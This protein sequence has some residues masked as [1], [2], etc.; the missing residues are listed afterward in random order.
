MKYITKNEFK[1]IVQK[2]SKGN[3]RDFIILNTL[4]KSGVRAEELTNITHNDILEEEEQLIIRGKG[5]VIRNVDVPPDLIMLLQL[6]IK[7]NRMKKKDKLF[8]MTPRNLQYITKKY[9]DINPHA[10]R[11]SYAI[12][13]LRGTRNIRYV[14]IQLGHTGLEATQVYLKYMDF[15]QEKEKLGEIFS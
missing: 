2:A 5:N 10:F 6:Y 12:H 3:Y 7:N 14:Q 1:R 15:K 9:A 11:H 13:L 4:F 8:D